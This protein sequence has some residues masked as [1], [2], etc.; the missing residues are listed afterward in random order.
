MKTIFKPF[1]L[2][3]ILQLIVILYAIREGHI[4]TNDSKEY[5]TQAHNLLQH[6]STYCGDY[7]SP[8][9][10][11][12]LYNRRPPGYA[13]FL[14]L[15]SLF[16]SINILPLFVQGA[17]SVF[18]I[19]IGYKILQEVFKGKPKLGLYLSF[20][21]FFPSQFIYAGVFMA[22][23][24]FQSA[25]L[26]C[27][28][29]ILRF[30]KSGN[31]TYFYI[32]HLFLALSYLI[33]PVTFFLWV[34][35]AL[36]GITIKHNTGISQ[37]LGLMSLAHV[38]LIGSF[39]LNNYFLTGIA[40]YSNISRKLLVNY[41]IPAVLTYSYGAEYANNKTDSISRQLA[42]Q[43]YPVE[44]A[45]TDEYIRETFLTRP[46]DFIIVQLSGVPRFFLESC[47]WDLELLTSGKDAADTGPSLIHLYR[48]NGFSGIKK[49]THQWSIVYLFYYILVVLAT[50]LIVLLF[51]KG[52]FM[53][54]IPRRY[55]WLFTGLILYL[56]ILT[57]PSASARF[58]MPVF[59][60][61]ALVAF[62]AL[63]SNKLN[64]ATPAALPEREN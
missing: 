18:N 25:L 61:I 5:L 31:S 27:L 9:R 15:S 51:I 53:K 7:D 11:E 28:Y 34:A 32:H 60:I 29:F 16:F 19:Y 13:V 52:L 40:E 21:I 41:T 46:V 23:I 45:M 30:E 36:Y 38:L 44:C 35:C 33:K 26:L 14:I 50:F 22:E 59:P 42:H 20:F 57:G 4:Y 17:L 48:L 39:F 8:L 2:I 24:P 49:I 62:S 6:G 63:P 54:N 47:R 12:S 64:E 3:S 1:L 10:D 55:R 58:R 56:A 43:P 37:R